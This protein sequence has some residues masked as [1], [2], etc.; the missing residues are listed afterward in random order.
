MLYLIILLYIPG[1]TLFTQNNPVT[2]ANRKVWTMHCVF[3]ALM[4]LFSEQ[5]IH[6]L[7]VIVIVHTISA[8][9]IL[10][11]CHNCFVFSRSLVT[12]TFGTENIKRDVILMTD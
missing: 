3:C 2:E 6:R 10:C 12:A 11:G 8:V 5:F 4:A 1:N 7:F 9:I